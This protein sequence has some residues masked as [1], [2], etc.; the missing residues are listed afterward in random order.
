MTRRK[1]EITLPDIKRHWP[2]HVA[3]PAERVRGFKNSE[4]CAALQVQPRLVARSDRRPPSNNK[5]S[6]PGLMARPW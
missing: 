3:L 6:D 4:A 5:D 1:G 2:H